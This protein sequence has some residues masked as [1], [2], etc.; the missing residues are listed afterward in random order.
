M[1][2]L[3]LFSGTHAHSHT[4]IHARLALLLPL[5]EASRAMARLRNVKYPS[6][7]GSNYVY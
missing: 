1:R 2:L 3:K 7:G 4:T 6:G 5:G